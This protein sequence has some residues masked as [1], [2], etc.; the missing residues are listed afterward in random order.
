MKLTN[1]R[2]ATIRVKVKFKDGGTKELDLKPNVD[3]DDPNIVM[4]FAPIPRGV[5]VG[6]SE[7][8]E[9]TPELIAPPVVVVAEPAPEPI[10]EP[11]KEEPAP[12]PEKPETQPEVEV[13]KE[14]PV[15]EDEKPLSP[16]ERRKLARK[17]AAENKE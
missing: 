1:S 3:L 13:P 17:K 10:P 16:S 9:P 5:M 6:P 11:P 8:S 12:E 2:A 7:A 14:E 15:A 4:V